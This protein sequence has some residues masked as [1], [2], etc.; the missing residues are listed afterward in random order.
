MKWILSISFLTAAVLLAPAGLVYAMDA[1]APPLYRE[2][3]NN[4]IKFMEGGVGINERTAMDSRADEYNLKLVFEN[5][6]G[7]YVGKVEVAIEDSSGKTA[8]RMEDAGPWFFANLPAG[9][10]KVVTTF[11]GTKAVRYAQLGRNQRTL[12][13]LWKDPGYSGRAH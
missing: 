11:K 7:M 12:R 9:R 3:I 13:F 8:I 5:H 1:D 4:G 2:G 6:A 10:Y